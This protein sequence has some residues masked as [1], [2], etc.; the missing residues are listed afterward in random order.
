[1]LIFPLGA[2]E[3]VF[4]DGLD[5]VGGASETGGAALG[6]VAVSGCVPLF[7]DSLG[8]HPHNNG[9]PI[10]HPVISAPRNIVRRCGLALARA[11]P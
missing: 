4:A 7:V 5:V 10:A 11:S 2:L 8:L 3:S 9:N 6:G 1:M